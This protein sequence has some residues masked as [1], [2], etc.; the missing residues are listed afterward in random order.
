MCGINGFNWPDYDLI[1]EMGKAIGHRGPDDSGSYVDDWTSLG[2]VRLSIIDLTPAG[3]QPMSNEDESI[4]IV[5]NGEVYNYLELRKILVGLGH[6][7]KSNTDTEVIVHAYEEWGVE[8]VHRFNG[9]WAFALY[10]KQRCSLFLSRDRFGIK[11]LYYYSQGRRF[12]FSSEIK[13]ILE[14]SI[15]R[16]P[17]DKSIRE[18]LSLG[19][20]DN[21][22]ETFFSDIQRLMAGENLLLDLG[23]GAFQLSKWYD[24]RRFASR[25]TVDKDF[26]PAESM[27]NHL[28]ASVRY[29]LVADVPIGSCLSG[30]ID[31]SSI[32][33]SVHSIDPERKIKTF[34]LVF[35]A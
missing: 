11:P 1:M 12:T 2:S 5:Y 9:M 17:C 19:H 34:S 16:S 20:V 7:F 4:W 21:G 33:C 14:H 15:P 13:G 3:R 24:L 6:T 18:Y 35:P 26:N 29:Q 32:V 8:C 30:G 23:S 28:L 25:R 10:D 22:R 31:S 27:R